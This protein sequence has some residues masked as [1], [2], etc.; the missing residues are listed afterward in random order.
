MARSDRP[1]PQ[2]NAAPNPADYEPIDAPLVSA[3]A[4]AVQSSINEFVLIFQQTRPVISKKTQSIADV[5]LNQPVAVVS[6]SPQTL[7]DMWLLI[8]DSVERY[9]KEF[10]QLTTPYMKRRA[11]ASGRSPS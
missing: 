3:S 7:K 1:G 2:A 4:V 11:A 9:E 6:V 5:A 8:G 10:G